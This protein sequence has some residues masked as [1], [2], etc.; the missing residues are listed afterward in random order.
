LEYTC[1]YKPNIAFF[2]CV[3][4]EGLAVLHRVC[5]ELIL[6]HNIPILL[7]V[8]RGDIGSTAT[9]YAQT[10][11]DTLPADA[12]T[13]SPLMGYDSI[14]PFIT[15]PYN[16]N[17]I[18]LLC[19]TSNA[20]SN[21]F[22]NLNIVPTNETSASTSTTLYE[23]IA[24]LTSNVWRPQHP[25]TTFGLVVGATDTMA[26]Q[27]V[28]KVITDDIW[29]LAP[30]IGAQGGNLHDACTYG[31]NAKGSGIILPI[32]RGIST[33]ANPKS[34]A[35][36]IRQLQRRRRYLSQ[37]HRHWTTSLLLFQLLRLHNN[38]KITKKNSYSSVYN[39]KF[40]NLVHIL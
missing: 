13:V 6:P 9:A 24:S 7:D 29:I 1:C 25:S 12:I 14:L 31:M 26:L 28:R 2:E 37:Q 10:C 39:R 22:L 3:G 30:G 17:G 19:K 35:R 36:E 32:S 23:H 33:A 38:Y 27:N 16:E 20:G 4:S 5:T 11:F 21:D 34:A 40:C 15:S 8:K 18:F